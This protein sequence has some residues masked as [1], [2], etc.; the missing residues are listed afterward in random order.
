MLKT[1]N[2][3]LKFGIYALNMISCHIFV[4]V[5]SYSA[6]EAFYTFPILDY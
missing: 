5:H 3:M 4:Q 2:V 6:C 1:D